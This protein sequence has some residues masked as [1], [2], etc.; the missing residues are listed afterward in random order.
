MLLR[1]AVTCQEFF[2][3]FGMGEVQPAAPGHQEFTAYG[4]F[5]VIDDDLLPCADERFGGD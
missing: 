5:A 2:Q 1:R 3:W 4:G